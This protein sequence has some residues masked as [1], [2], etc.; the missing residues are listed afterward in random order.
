[1]QIHGDGPVQLLV[2][3]CNQRL[4]L[5]AMA[6][7]ADNVTIAD[8][9]ALADLINVSGH[10]RFVITLDPTE[11]QAGHQPYQG[12]VPIEGHSIAAVI[13]TY[14][15]Q[16]EQLDTRLWLAADTQV[17]RGMLLQRLPHVGGTTFKLS[18][19][20]HSELAEESWNRASIIGGTLKREELLST[21]ITTLFH[22][23][24]WEEELRVF[25]PQNVSFHCSCSRDRVGH[26]LKLLGEDEVM[27]A[28]ASLGQLD[29]NCDFC[30]KLYRFDA[31]DCAQ[32][33]LAPEV[34][35][36]SESGRR[37]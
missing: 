31:V 32:L 5:R 30:G 28:I 25:E 37:H 2:V 19:E 7:L 21:S 12:T 35:V 10:G 3:E 26:M 17:S 27:D 29:I 13:E 1:M 20:I 22:R 15:K 24:F 9:A 8:D 4:E 6:K 11:R 16:S 14:M 34:Q 33:F 23:L 18:D 36:S